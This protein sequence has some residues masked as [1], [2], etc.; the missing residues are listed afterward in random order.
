MCLDKLLFFVQIYGGWL[1]KFFKQQNHIT[2][3]RNIIDNDKKQEQEFISILSA[4]QT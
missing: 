1:K 2:T 4:L 3:R